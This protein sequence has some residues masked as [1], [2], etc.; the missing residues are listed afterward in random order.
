MGF[1]LAEAGKIV[2]H[3]IFAGDVGQDLLVEPV[4]DFGQA[5]RIILG[6]RAG[7]R[8]D[9]LAILAHDLG[10]A[11]GG[12]KGHDIGQRHISAG[13][14]AK[15]RAVD[16]IRCQI[17][18][19]QLDHDLHAARPVGEACGLYPVKPVAQFRADAI[20]GEAQRAALRGQ[21]QDQF[22]LVIGQRI[23]KRG[24]FG[25]DDQRA[26]QRLGRLFQRRGV[27]AR[28]F[29]VDIVPRRPPAAAPERQFVDQRAVRRGLLQRGDEV[30]ARPGAQVGIAEFY[31]HRALQVAFGIFRGR[32]PAPDIRPHLSG[33]EFQRLDPVFVPILLR[34]LRDGVLKRAHHRLAVFAGSA[35]QH[36]EVGVDSRLLGRV[37]EAPRNVA[38]DELRR[39][40]AQK[41]DGRRHDRIARP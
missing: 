15:Q 5:I 22:V 29:H 27:I 16:E 33:D 11:R 35:G 7:D 39:L 12:I 9:L 1:L 24:H 37:E 18:F 13:R 19:R 8:Y 23:L 4:E 2:G 20:D 26:F 32:Q 14:G 41:R 3:A 6:H 34:D 17:A 28:Q 25:E 40:E 30:I 31:R 36:G 38:A 10:K 21:G